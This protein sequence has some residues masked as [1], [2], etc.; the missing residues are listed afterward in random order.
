MESQSIENLRGEIKFREKLA[1]QHVTG[2]ILLPDYYD[3]AQH[4][5]IL[6]DRIATTIRDIEQL[7]GKGVHLSPFIELGAERCQRSLVMTNDF[8]AKGFAVDI[9]YHQ[10]NAARHFS[11]IFDR[12][13]LPLRVC[14]DV[15]NLPFQQNAF[16][17]VFC[18]QFIHHFPSPKTVLN[19]AYRI[20]ANGSL[21]FSEEPFK[22]FKIPLYTQK[23]SLYSQA[24]LRKPKIVRFI[25]R[26]ISEEYCDEREYGILENDDIELAEWLDSLR[27]F[28]S[29]EVYIESAGGRIRTRIDKKIAIQNILNLIFGGNISALCQKQTAEIEPAAETLEDLLVCPDCL[30]NSKDNNSKD[31]VVKHVPLKRMGDSLI[32]PI[33]DTSF[34]IINDVIFLFPTALFRELYPEFAN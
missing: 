7:I 1:Q 28:D 17:F 9:S 33:C 2:E 23:N 13:N 25:E 10:L 30:N 20:L 4:D 3:K 15:N 16:S 8:Q 19:E 24:T 34:P 14:C 12:P 6:L 27:Q 31:S 22:G 32:C 26:F 5:Q 21:F 29:A 18:Y 11:E